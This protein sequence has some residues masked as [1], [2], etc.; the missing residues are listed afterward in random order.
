LSSDNDDIIQRVKILK[1]KYMSNNKIYIKRAID[2]MEGDDD[3]ESFMISFML[4]FL[5]T[6][7]C[8]GTSDSVDWKFLFSLVDVSKIPS[9]DWP[10]LCLQWTVNEVAKYKKK[11][12]AVRS[13]KRKQMVYVG[14]CLPSMAVSSSFDVSFCLQRLT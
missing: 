5:G 14:G 10:A 12:S 1:E 8:P 13:G 7:V 9:V 4:V 6:I 11:I 2:L 3:E